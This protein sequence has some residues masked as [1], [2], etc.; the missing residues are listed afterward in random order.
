VT[1][2]SLS[3]QDPV[4][5]SGLPP[6]RLVGLYRL[7]ALA[8]AL[9][10]RASILNRAGRTH[11]VISG[12]GHE[13]AEVGVTSALVPGRD[14]FLPYYRSMAGVMA[15][16]MTPREVFLLQF[17]KADDPGSGGRQMPSHYGHAGHRIFT[18]SSPVATQVLH[19][20]GIALAAKLRGASEV[21]LAA[22]G[23]G[24][25][26]QGDVH[27]ALNFAGIH[28]L[29][30]I[31]LVEN[32]G[33][34]IS[35]PAERE[36][37]V[38]DIA[39]RAAG[40][41]IPGVVVD[42]ADVIDCHL[43]AREAV[44]RALAGEGPTLIEAKVPRLTGHSS[45]DQQTKYR[46]REELSEQMAR[47]PLPRFRDELRAAGLLHEA[48]EAAIAAEVRAAVDDATDVAEGAAGP[49]PSTLL[50][51]VHAEQGDPVPGPP[52]PVQAAGLPP[53]DKAGGL[54]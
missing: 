50:R 37:A 27:E 12:Q 43:A 41:G 32:N 4:A 46:S 40:Y 24:S 11:F 33:Y 9:D 15:M 20:A 3:A 22:M 28:R 26:N 45:D 7:M 39:V 8:R 35:V 31:L 54:V 23:E 38:R 10:E 18:S 49:D 14:W 48:A 52:S 36:S 6:Q 17:G 13:G 25:S 44:R 34:A 53:A 5:R 16:G 42:G 2:G 47:D 1:T 29:P 21:A 19:A 30:M 51:H